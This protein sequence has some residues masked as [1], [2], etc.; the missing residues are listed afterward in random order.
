M[1]RVTVA[2]REMPLSLQVS[3]SIFFSRLEDE[4][5]ACQ[6]NRGGRSGVGGRQRMGDE[7]EEEEEG[8]GEN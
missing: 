2:I 8:V 3:R 7:E 5:E 6:I 1:S 4:T